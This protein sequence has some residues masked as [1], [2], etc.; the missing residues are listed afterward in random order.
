ME[1][2][3]INSIHEDIKIVMIAEISLKLVRQSSSST[4]EDGRVDDG[5]RSECDWYSV[6]GMEGPNSEG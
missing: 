2:L 4:E 1:K 5:I 6:C 3:G